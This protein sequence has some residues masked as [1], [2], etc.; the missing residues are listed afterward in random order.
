VEDDGPPVPDVILQHLGEPF[1][2]TKPAGTGLGLAIVHAIAEAHG[3]SL[4]LA[5]NR[6]GQVRFE[7]ILPHPAGAPR[8]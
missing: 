6:P 8:P 1:H 4:R 2:S 3:G 7:L 5:E